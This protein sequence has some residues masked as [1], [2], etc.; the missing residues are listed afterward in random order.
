MKAEVN[1]Q[2]NKEVSQVKT[3]WSDEEANALFEQGWSLLHGGVA[4]KDNMGYR[5]KPFYVMGKILAK[6]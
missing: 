3:V 6:C 4:H 2:E 1:E 5:A